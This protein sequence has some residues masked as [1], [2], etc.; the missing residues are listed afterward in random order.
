MGRVVT[1][2]LVDSLM[3]PPDGGRRDGVTV[4]AIAEELAAHRQPDATAATIDG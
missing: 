1:S 4:L 3:V 2:E